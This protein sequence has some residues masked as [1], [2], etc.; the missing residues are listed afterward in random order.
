MPEAM[1]GIEITEE[2]DLLLNAERLT[3]SVIFMAG[4]TVAS[5]DQDHSSPA[6]AARKAGP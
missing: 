6:M 3:C 1:V 2:V 4:E 5:S